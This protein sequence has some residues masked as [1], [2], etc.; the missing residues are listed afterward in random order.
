[1]ADPEGTLLGLYRD[2]RAPNQTDGGSGVIAGGEAIGRGRLGYA[3]RVF[4]RLMLGKTN[5]CQFERI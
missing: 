4:W 3:A 5:V 2:L 1:M